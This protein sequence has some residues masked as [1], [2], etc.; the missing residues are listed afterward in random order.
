MKGKTKLKRRARDLSGRE[1][2]PKDHQEWLRIAE[3]ASLAGD[4]LLCEY[5]WEKGLGLRMLW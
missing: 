5:A 3:E 1:S 4:W 2:Y